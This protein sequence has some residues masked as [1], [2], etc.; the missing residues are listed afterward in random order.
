MSICCRESSRGLAQSKTL[1]LK[2]SRME[3]SHLICVLTAAVALALVGCSK[4]PKAADSEQIGG[5]AVE[6]P[7]LQHGLGTSKAQW[8]RSR[9]LPVL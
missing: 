9:I 8:H 4:S 6:M 2:A 3:L 7:K 5:I 1:R